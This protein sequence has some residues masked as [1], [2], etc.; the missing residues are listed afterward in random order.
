MGCGVQ[1]KS[2]DKPWISCRQAPHMMLL[3]SIAVPLVALMNAF[4]VPVP[5]TSLLPS[6]AVSFSLPCLQ[7]PVPCT[8][9][10]R[11]HSALADGVGGA[12]AAGR[13]TVSA[14]RILGIHEWMDGF[15]FVAT[16]CVCYSLLW[17]HGAHQQRTEGSMANVSSPPLPTHSDQG[18]G[19]LLL[20]IL[21]LHGL[22]RPSKQVLLEKYTH[23]AH[24]P[25]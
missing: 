4:G 21:P 25:T 2:V 7:V 6:N 19:C 13:P 9:L 10:L 20:H 14:Q 5:C 18:S 16:D 1:T 24:R 15:A 22:P 12:G 11:A 23:A 3:L 17:M 8:R